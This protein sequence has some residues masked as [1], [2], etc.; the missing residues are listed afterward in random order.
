[1]IGLFL[2]VGA[3][4]ALVTTISAFTIAHSLTL[5]AAVL[6]LVGNLSVI[7]VVVSN[8]QMRSTTNILIISL[9]VAD[10]LFIVICVPFTAIAYG[11]PFWPFGTVFCKVRRNDISLLQ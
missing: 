7:I 10:L 3:T 1:M 2:L 4:R 6:G 9:A 11:T 8:L 5:A